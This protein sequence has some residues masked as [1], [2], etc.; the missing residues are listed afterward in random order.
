MKKHNTNTPTL[1]TDRL[2]LRKFTEH[3]VEALFE[4]LRDKEVN[5]FLPWF[6]VKN[7]EETFLHLKERYLENYKKIQSYHYAICLKTDNVPIGYVNISDNDSYDLGYGIKKEFWHKKIT[8]EACQA[9][10]KE[11]KLSGIPYITATH[12]INNPR[13]GAVMKRLGMLYQ[14]SYEE[15]VQPKNIL[16]I[17]NMYQLNFDEQKDRIYK[18]YWY[19][20]PVHF[21][22][23]ED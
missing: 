4:I 5:T 17:F 7:I 2:I 10:I 11:L 6:P 22:K 15:W 8:T 13:S 16:V 20:Y 23:K 1:E 12:D 19:K 3:D 21:I 18:K 9:V 14:Y